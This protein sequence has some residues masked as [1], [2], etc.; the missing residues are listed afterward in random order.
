MDLQESER[1]G[2]QSDL[3][4]ALRTSHCARGC[5][6]LIVSA[7]GLWVAEDGVLPLIIIEL[8]IK[9]VI[10]KNSRLH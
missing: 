8:L 9:K 2:S 6:S 4:F 3:Y 7:L 1:K 5:S 10:L